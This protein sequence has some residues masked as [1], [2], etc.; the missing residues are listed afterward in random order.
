MA[1]KLPL[2][3]PEF[4]QNTLLKEWNRQCRSGNL[5]SA[6][7]KHWKTFALVVFANNYESSKEDRLAEKF[8]LRPMEHFLCNG[9]PETILKSLKEKDQ[10][11][12]L[13]GKVFKNGEPT[14]S[15]R[16]CANDNTCVLCIDCFQKSA[17]KKH[18]YKMS[19]SGGGGYCD[20]GDVE[21][22]KSDPY[23]EIHDAKTK[24]MSDQNPIEVL[25]EDLTDRASALFMATLHYVVQMLTWEQ[26]DC[27]PSEIQPEGELDDSYITM[28]FNDELHTYEQ[29]INTLQRAVECTQE[30]AV[31]HAT[32]VDREGRSSVRDGTFSF[33]EKA[34][35]IIEH[36]TSRHGSKPLKV[37]IMHT[38]V[39]AHQKF[40]LKLVTW[41]QDII[42][43]SDGLRRLFCTLSTQPYE[44]GESLIEKLILSDTQMWKNARMLV[45]Q[46]M[47]SGVLM[48]QECKKQFSIIFTKH[49]EAITREFVSD[50]HNRPVSITSLSVQ[51][52]T[53]P[54]V[55]KMLVTDH[56]LLDVI[57][58]TFLGFCEEKKNNDGKLSFERNERSTSFKRACYVLYDVKYAL[59]CRPSPDEWSD[60]LR[61]S[62]LKGFKSFLK[63]LKMMQG[64]D[65][66]MR[67]LGVHLEYEPEWEGAFNLQ[68]KQDDVITE[69]LEWCG[70]DRKV[71]IEAFKLTLEFLL[72]CKDKPA[73]VKRE[74]KTVCG[75]K[76]RCLKYD[77]STQ[78]V[79]IHLPLSR[80]LA[81]LFLHFGKLGIA[82]NSH[83]VNIEHLDMA[84]IIEPPLRV[85]VMVAQ[86]QAGMWRRNG[87]SLL[88]QIF[89]YHNVKC[90]RE[91]FDKDINM[92]QIGASIMDNN[93]FLIHL[94]NKYNLLSW[95]RKDYDTPSGQEDMVRQTVTLAEEFLTLLITIISERYVLGIG[96]MDEQ[97]ITKREIIHQ[98]CV[99]PMSYSELTKGLPVNSNHETGIEE[100]INDVAVFK[101]PSTTMGGKGIFE[102]K[103]EFYKEYTRFFLHY[104]RTEQS[105]SEEA[106][107]KRKKDAKEDHALPPP[108]PPKVTPMFEPLVG[109][110]QC[111]IM[112]HI[113][114]LILQRTVAVRSRSW[115]EAQVDRVLH[116][117]GL[118][119]HEQRRATTEGNHNF[120][121]LARA[122][123]DDRN[124]LTLLESLVADHRNI[125]HDSTD[126]LLTW[127]V[128]QFME[129]R[130][131]TNSNVTSA[132]ALDELSASTRQEIELA[133]RQKAEIAAKRREKIMAKISKMQK[134]FI[135]D[136][137]D[138][139]ESTDAELV[140]TPSDMDV[141]ISDSRFPVALGRNQ[142]SVGY[143]GCQHATC[144]L[145]QEEQDV[146]HNSRAMVLAAYIQRST[147][148][149]QNRSKVVL[150]GDKYDPTFMSADLNTDVHTSSCGHVMHADCW[151]RFFDA[152]LAKERRGRPFRFRPS[153]SYNVDNSEF[154]CPLCE[155]I[156]NTVIPIVPVLSSLCKESDQ[157]SIYITFNDW[158]D[159]LQKT[160]QH[161][162]EKAKEN[163]DQE[164][165]LLFKPCPLPVVTR[166]LA[167]SVAR[168]FQLLWDYVSEDGSEQFS[169]SMKDM[170]KK[171]A[172]DSYSFG[173]GVEPDETNPRVPIMAWNTCAFTIQ[174]IE[175]ML[176]HDQKPLFGSLS[177][178]Q[179]D[180]MGSLVR[181]AAVCGQVMNSDLVKQHCLKVLS[182]LIMDSTQANENMC[183]L[184]VDLFHYLTL[185]TMTLPSLHVEGQRSPL[186][187]I[188][189]GGINN[190][191]ALELVFT[192]HLVQIML[193]CD[194]PSQSAME[195]E[196]DSDDQKML[197]I[198]TNVRQLA[199]IHSQTSPQ[200][201]Q[202]T[203]M[204]KEACLPFL[205]CAAILYHHIT[206][207]PVPNILQEAG[208]D[209]FEPIC[210]YL[211]ISSPLSSLFETQGDIIQTLVMR[212]CSNST[213]RDRF[214]ASSDKIITYPLPIN[215]LVPLPDD[216]SEL[217]NRDSTFTCPKSNGDDTRA[218]TM[219]LVCGQMLCSQSYCCQTEL[220]GVKVGAA[221]EHSYKCGAGVGIFLRVRECQV[222]LLTGKTKGCFVPPPYLDSYG[223]TDQGLR[224]GN[225]LHLCP[226]SYKNL[227]K[228]WF[229]HSLPETIS[230]SLETNTNLLTFDWQHL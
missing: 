222:L 227:Q 48:D 4:C 23:C 102:L 22:W 26:C 79:S 63:M 113:M 132:S 173:L 59:I 220:D 10:P 47:M 188:P 172:S 3:A 115:S 189:T 70:T 169:D 183:I 30:E 119:L 24:P 64:M 15:C 18:R 163:E 61:H 165:S 112:V 184:D 180:C 135:Q 207:I 80:I 11:S 230:H 129:I 142:T 211:A 85:Q 204:V 121:F 66:V 45:H 179:S 94:L 81:G 98:L 118:A 75:H 150:N 147:V 228:L 78:P 214:S 229:N 6:L 166:M 87:Y 130:Q 209:Q 92:L 134:N 191:H 167:E 31:E 155:C 12:Q 225:P 192:A 20:C 143:V 103:P 2:Q 19:T 90:R 105:K 100:V 208:C 128:K 44:N 108:V 148:L 43:K 88:N 171:F 51:I 33:C 139:F 199:G 224:R 159:G 186:S 133:K 40:A 187:I 226:D 39:V 216:Y 178:R 35:H 123:K 144:I 67:Q 116:L 74:D 164:D 162:I 190:H 86:T 131:M 95:V 96:T 120:D 125:S 197:E 157:K 137:A 126:N 176:R 146:R 21:A 28:L 158:I 38:I 193:V 89:F 213:L 36:S 32:I 56:D 219:C 124:I 25:P 62:F 111:D 53:V 60:K 198:Y 7:Q 68:L 160:V 109:L 42:G 97:D 196:T 117:I 73:T 16:D 14:Y 151:Q 181:F 76:V 152:L 17:H 83:E 77:V 34:R 49:Y 156:S 154:L 13:C 141:S 41:L 71:L 182:F 1:L 65:G 8:L 140:K 110:L 9:D 195:V 174:S 210:R 50:D 202:V 5:L 194:I 93:E 91:M 185:L 223:E 37:Q 175:Q 29:V 82:W 170:I 212:W 55:A 101:K 58:T 177:S 52:F 217:I 57:I 106:Q 54:S 200:P 138:L 218:P 206:S 153:L 104:S 145:C 149:S 107:M 114:H 72:K 201:W 46:M 122:L 221:T 84:E 215:R 161:S 203:Q 99:A 136:N 127:V 27:L 168:N 69:F 205:R